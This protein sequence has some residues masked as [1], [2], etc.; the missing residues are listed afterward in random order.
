MVI[1]VVITEKGGTGDV[2]LLEMRIHI[3]PKDMG[4]GM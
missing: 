3:L 4:D 1:N 2:E